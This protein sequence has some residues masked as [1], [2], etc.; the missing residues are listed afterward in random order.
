MKKQTPTQEALANT[1][2]IRENIDKHLSDL[3]KFCQKHSFTV[4]VPELFADDKNHTA[5][6][7]WGT[8]LSI[9]KAN[10]LTDKFQLEY[11]YSRLTIEFLGNVNIHE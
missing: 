7:T 1:R 8:D 2:E 9:N 4:N 10:K 3:D 11:Q 6:M 5:V